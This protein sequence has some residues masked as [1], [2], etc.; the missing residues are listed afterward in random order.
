MRPS[1]PRTVIAG[2]AMISGTKMRRPAMLP[3]T[4]PLWIALLVLV[5][6]TGGCLSDAG[7][8]DYDYDNPNDTLDSGSS[9]DDDDSGL[10]I[11]YVNQDN[12]D[13]VVANFGL[14]TVDM[15]GYTIQEQNNDDLVFEFPSFELDSG[16]I[17]RIHA[18][19]GD[20]G[21]SNDLYWDDA[22]GENVFEGGDTAQL[23]NASGDEESSCSDGEECW[24]DE[25]N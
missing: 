21:D 16:K 7:D 5:L 13:V 14:E 19:E 23:K 20:D 3:R 24:A 12:D 6:L 1:I 4:R 18:E 15:T 9:G 25:V 10:A 17:V 22:Q 8:T 11:V 2:T